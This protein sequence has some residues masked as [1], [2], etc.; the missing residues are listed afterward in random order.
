M[1]IG[2]DIGSTTIKIAVM[3]DAGN[4]LFHKY[5]RHYSQIAEKILALHKELIT[6]FPTL[7]SARLAISGS[8]GIGVADSC[9]LQFVQ[10]VFAEKICAE[11][12]NPNRRRYRIRWRG[13]KDSLLRPP[14]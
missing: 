3:D 4:L 11:K 12:L 8:G 5:E 10:E 14:F 6:K 9:G 13:C 2:L 1:Q 7:H